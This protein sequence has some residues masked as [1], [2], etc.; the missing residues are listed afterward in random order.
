MDIIDTHVHVI[1]KN[2]PDYPQIHVTKLAWVPTDAKDMEEIVARMDA[3]GVTGAVLVQALAGHGYDNRYTLDSS[4]RHNKQAGAV[5]RQRFTPVGMID[6]LFKLQGI[7]LNVG[8]DVASAFQ[9]QEELEK[10]R[11]AAAAAKP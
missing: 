11:K 7:G 1:A 6:P 2:Q 10:K 8:P 3:A 9:R 4:I 5:Q